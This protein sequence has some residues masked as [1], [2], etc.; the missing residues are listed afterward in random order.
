M[1]KSKQIIIDFESAMPRF[2]FGKDLEGRNIT[3]AR[4]RLSRAWRTFLKLGNKG[5]SPEDDLKAR[6]AIL[7]EQQELEEQ[8]RE[9]ARKE[10]LAEK[11]A[12]EQKP[13]AEQFDLKE[14]EDPEQ[15]RIEEASRKQP[16]VRDRVGLPD[17]KI[18]N[19]QGASDGSGESGTESVESGAGRGAGEQGARDA[20]AGERKLTG[21]ASGH[22]F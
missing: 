20:E 16:K 18:A 22:K 21:T 8:A 12:I 11:K 3:V 7:K 19:K 13:N 2:T 14:Y 5:I 1:P 9:E 10:Y 6:Q 15:K 17:E 4:A